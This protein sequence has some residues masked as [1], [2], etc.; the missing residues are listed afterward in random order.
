MDAINRKLVEDTTLGYQNIKDAKEKVKDD[1]KTRKEQTIEETRALL[2][3]AEEESRLERERRDE[4]IRQ[5]RALE[6]VPMSR[7]K[8]NLIV[9]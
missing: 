4:V 7:F 5:I 1:N 6:S 3:Q 2:A 9:F 8:V